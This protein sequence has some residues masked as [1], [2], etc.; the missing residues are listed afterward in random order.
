MA[1]FSHD[2]ERSIPE[3]KV[4]RKDFPDYNTF[5]K[6]HA[7]NSAKIIEEIMKRHG[8]CDEVVRDVTSLVELHETGGSERAN[9][10]KDADSIS[11]FDTNLAFYAKRNSMEDVIERCVWGYKRISPENRGIVIDILNKRN[12][13]LHKTIL[14]LLRE[15]DE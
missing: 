14:A 4:K 12:N 9:I 13:E 6:A 2:I 11:F 8:A 5:K 1:A 10:L 15:I 7:K 3:K